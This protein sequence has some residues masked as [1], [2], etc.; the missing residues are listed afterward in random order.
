[1]P[2]ANPT[3]NSVVTRA[4]ETTLASL[5]A[6]FPASLPGGWLGISLEAQAIPMAVVG[7]V[8]VSGIVGTVAVT[9]STLPW[10]VGDGGGS[11]TVDGAVSLAAAIPAG[12]NTI[13]KVDQGAGG[14]LAWKVDGSAVVQPVSATALPLPVGAA[15]ELTLAT[16]A[17]EVTLAGVLTTAAFQGRVNTLGQKPSAT[18]MPVVLASDQ[19]Q[20]PVGQASLPWFVAT[21]GANTVAVTAPTMT[22]GVQGA[23]GLS[24]Q[25]LKDAGRVRVVISFEAVAPGVVDTL[26]LLVKKLDGV[27]AAAATTIPVTAGKRLRIVAVSFSLRSAAAAVAFGTLTLR[28][29]PAGA[30]LIASPS[31]GRLDVSTT[32]VVGASGS[33]VIAFPDGMEFSGL[34]QI[35]ASVIAQAITNIL[36]VELYGFEY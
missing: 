12:A 2:L 25:S 3:E 11:L 24:V 4:S 31:W 10:V 34:N 17:S 30:V 18:S 33:Q 22:K 21:T 14:L 19:T 27:P 36:S 7:T 9:Q 5:S 29:N 23:Q 13:G 28:E 1:V 15:T 35:G 26:L 8:A 16:R 20:I 6:K 32:N